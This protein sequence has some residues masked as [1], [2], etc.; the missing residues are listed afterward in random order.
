MSPGCTS[1]QEVIA[2]K[3]KKKAM[4]NDLSMG[5]IHMVCLKFKEVGVVGGHFEGKYQIF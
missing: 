1:P 4:E 5:K 2:I 3:K